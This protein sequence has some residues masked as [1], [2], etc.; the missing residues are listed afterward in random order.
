MQH[1]K[2]A[3]IGAGNM[4]SSIIYGIVKDGYPADCILACAPSLNNTEKLAEKLTIKT[5]QHNQRA[6]YWAD[7]IVLAVKPQIMAEVCQAMI[8]DG[9][10]FEN[11]LIISIIAGVCVDRLVSL[12][13]NVAIIR[14]MP[15][16]PALI[17]KG[18]TGLF[19]PP[20]V[21]KADRDFATNLMD[22][23]GKTLWVEK[24]SMINAIIATS[25]SS[26]AY[27]FLFMQAMQEK[28]V[29]LGFS[30]QEARLLVQQSAIGSAEMV[31]N[32]THLSLAT[33]RQNV[34]S[35]GGV[36]AEAINLMSTFK[37]PESIKKA[38]QAAVDRGKEMEIQL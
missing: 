36:T 19:A 25:G 18:M 5:S 30:S 38:M 28:A 6:V 17:Q 29:E 15:N 24:E 2:I 23:V 4:A 10:N 26:P 27:F 14:T 11:K 20:R 35:Q 8:D 16:T 32:N 21:S 34:T 13:G 31:A 7:V 33:L 3:F 37:V 12:L 22:V 1:K 9:A